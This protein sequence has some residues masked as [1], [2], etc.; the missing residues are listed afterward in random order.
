MIYCL[1]I[2]LMLLDQFSC[3]FG[4]MFVLV[5]ISA[6]SLFFLSLVSVGEF[7]NIHAQAFLL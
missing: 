2:N 4:K 6:E 3:S 5:P 1:W 7:V